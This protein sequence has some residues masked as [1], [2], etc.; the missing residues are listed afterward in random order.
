MSQVSKAYLFGMEMIPLQAMLCIYPTVQ[1][2]K[3][4]VFLQNF[5]FVDFMWKVWIFFVVTWTCK[6]IIFFAQRKVKTVWEKDAGET[7][8]V[9]QKYTNT[10][11]LEWI[12]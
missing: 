12:W 6:P 9:T 2:L 3:I 7:R 1:F 8:L 10:V 4:A 5:S 11:A